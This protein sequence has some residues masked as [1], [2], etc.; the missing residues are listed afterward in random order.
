MAQNSVR[1]PSAGER[2][3]GGRCPSGLASCAEPLPSA[4]SFRSAALVCKHF[5]RLLLSPPLLRNLHFELPGDG[6]DMQRHATMLAAWLRRHATGIVTSLRLAS[7]FPLN[8]GAAEDVDVASDALE[9]LL[10][11]LPAVNSNGQLLELAVTFCS[12]V[13]ALPATVGTPPAR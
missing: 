11:A 12:P 13:S 3:T 2:C 7:D 8:P 4:R 6:T 5:H 1:V 10:A 9:S